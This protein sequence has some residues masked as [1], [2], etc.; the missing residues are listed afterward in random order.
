MPTVSDTPCKYCQSEL[1][2]V[3]AGMYQCTKC[4]RA[5]DAKYVK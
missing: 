4:G 5:V 3:S 1:E 2:K